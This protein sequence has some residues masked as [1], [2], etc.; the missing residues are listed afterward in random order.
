MA[1]CRWSSFIK[2][3]VPMEAHLSKKSL[4]DLEK[5]YEDE[6][7]DWYIFDNVY[8][9]TTLDTQLLSIWNRHYEDNCDFQYPE[10]KRMY[11]TDDWSNLPGEVTQK[12]FLR[13]NVKRWLDDVEEEYGAN[14]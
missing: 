14:D 12:E 3:R 6:L 11:E 13:T 2:G 7:S 8:G 1:Y 9:G 4:E 5:E 10:V